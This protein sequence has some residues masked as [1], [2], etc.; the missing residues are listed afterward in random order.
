M[1]LFT[2]N[3]F[4]K[5]DSKLLSLKVQ[6]IKILNTSLTNNTCYFNS[7]SICSLIKS[8]SDIKNNGSMIKNRSYKNLFLNN[9]YY[10]TEY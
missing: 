5:I 7:Y 6:P 1:K 8:S 4:F 9:F 10:Y 3:N 2:K